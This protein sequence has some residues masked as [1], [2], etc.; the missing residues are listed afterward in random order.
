MR[1]INAMEQLVAETLHENWNDIT[2]TCKCD[3]CKA[4]VFALTLN[5]LPPR[6]VSKDNGV[7]YVKAQFFEKQMKANILVKI[8]VAT[9]RVSEQPQCE[10]W[11]RR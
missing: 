5:L 11:R 9:N 10:N 7:A 2:M 6:Y 1:V 8:A 3:Q 4:D